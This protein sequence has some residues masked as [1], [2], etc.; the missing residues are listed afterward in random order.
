M[1]LIKTGVIN[2][3]KIIILFAFMLIG[4]PS[5]VFSAQGPART[6]ILTDINNAVWEVTG[7]YSWTVP[8]PFVESRFRL[9]VVTDTFQVAIPPENLI[10]IE[11]KEEVV[12]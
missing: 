12:P 9:A 1:V 8:G 4:V 10:S 7:I 2:M 11:K 3:K 5:A 6:A